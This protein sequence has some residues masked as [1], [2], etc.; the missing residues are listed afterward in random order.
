MQV[1]IIPALVL[2]LSACAIQPNG[3]SDPMGVGKAIKRCLD[4]PSEQR[5][6]PDWL[7]IFGPAFACR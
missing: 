5:T 1:L 7:A 3:L 4:T 2:L 6:L